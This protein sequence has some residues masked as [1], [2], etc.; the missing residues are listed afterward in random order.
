MSKLFP[1]IREMMRQHDLNNKSFAEELG[2][3]A[4]TLSG[5]LNGHYPWTSDE[6]WKIMELFSIPANQLHCIFPRGGRN[7][8]NIKPI[9]R[10]A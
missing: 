10:T 8:A 3:A 9:K 7:P 2:I 4:S 5:K 1:K 6:M